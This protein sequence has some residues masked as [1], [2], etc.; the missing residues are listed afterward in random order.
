MNLEIH[1]EISQNILNW[2]PFPKD[3]KILQISESSDKLTEL[4]RNRCSEVRV[5][6]LDTIKGFDYKLEDRDKEI[7][8]TEFKKLKENL[9]GKSINY[10]DYAKSI[11]KMFIIDL[12]TIDNKINKY[13]IGGEEFV[14]HDALENY[15]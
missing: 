15:K 10:E 12:Y 8:K 2:Y 13:D 6:S 11:A 4:F 1:P 14:H 7:Y 9:E 3:Q 5:E